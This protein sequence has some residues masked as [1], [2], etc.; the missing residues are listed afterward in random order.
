MKDIF[1]QSPD[2]PIQL[3]S[4][5]ASRLFLDNLVSRNGNHILYHR[6]G[7]FQL[8]EDGPILDHYE[9]MSSDNRYDDFYINIYN[10]TNEWIPPDGYLFEYEL[11]DISFFLS[12]YELSELNGT[13]INIA[14]KYFFKTELGDSEEL[15]TNVNLPLLELFMNKSSG[16]NGCN[17]EFPYSRIKELIK[18]HRMYTSERLEEVL[19]SIK[20]R[21]KSKAN[22]E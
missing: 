14:G 7:S 3:N 15:T 10:E 8:K 19:T 12:D 13:E 6:R 22:T 21:G 16:V 5:V 9:V 4:I 17:D 18:N 20:P 1:G 11:A 2:N